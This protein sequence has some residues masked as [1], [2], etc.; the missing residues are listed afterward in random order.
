M[1][2]LR[3]THVLFDWGGTLMVDDPNRRDPMCQWPHVAEVAGAREV[4]TALEGKA[5]LAIATNAFPSDVEM[6]QQALER[7]NFARHFSSIFCG[8]ALGMS[9]TEP[10]F[11]R[12]VLT[13]L[14]APPDQV[15][16]V[17]DSFE[18]DVRVPT[19]MGIFSF[20]LNPTVRQSG[21]TGP[22]ATLQRLEDL[23]NFIAL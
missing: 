15:I 6:I 1:R 18:G 20:W 14:N 5:Q 21:L 11:W 22:F 7:V 3:P 9:K 12:H 13:T 4:L 8:P 2:P 23:L 10:R 17:G 19:S 16:M